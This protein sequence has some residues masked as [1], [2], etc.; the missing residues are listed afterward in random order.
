[1]F[2]LAVNVAAFVFPVTAV[3]GDIEQIFVEVHIIGAHERAG[4]FKKLFGQAGLARN[5]KGE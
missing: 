3:A 1:M 2:L 5:L 4:F